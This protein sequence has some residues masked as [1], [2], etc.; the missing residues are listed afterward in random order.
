MADMT[1]T[2]MATYL[3]EKWSHKASITYRS[4][5]ILTGLMDR[6]WEPELVEDGDTVNIPSFSQNTSATKRST[7][8]TGA[9]LTF[10]AVT[11]SQTQLLVNQMAYK[12]FRYPGELG[13][14]KLAVYEPLLTEGIGMAI[15]LKVDE[16]LA[17]D[18]SN[19]LDAFTAIGTDGQDITDDLILQGEE[20]LNDVNAP[21]D[22]RFCV[23]SPGTWTSLRKI[24][25]YKE[26]GFA[27]SM[28]NLDGQKGPGYLGKVYTLDFYMSNNLEAGTSGKKNAIWQREAIAF[29][30]QKK[31]TIVKDLNIEDGIFTQIAGWA[32]YGHKMV[33]STFGRELDGK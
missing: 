13:P 12:A 4:N 32:S 2:T 16:E 22:G 24:N 27:A 33:K 20:N 31:L 17:A 7:F 19:G 14:Q 18:N 15:A 25:V 9:S 23:V 5:T 30:M 28:G 29:A 11:E 21:L 1:A 3:P 8:G 26:A 6:R 10:D